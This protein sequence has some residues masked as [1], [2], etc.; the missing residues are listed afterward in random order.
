MVDDL[1]NAFALREVP[2]VL[3]QQLAR[4][5]KAAHLSAADCRGA[6]PRLT[7]GSC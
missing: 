7:S 5:P 1:K 2:F 6:G 4:M 3:M